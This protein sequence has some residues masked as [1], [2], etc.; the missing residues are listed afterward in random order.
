MQKKPAAADLAAPASMATQGAAMDRRITRSPWRRAGRWLPATAIV[1]TIG[2]LGIGF[3]LSPGA[4]SLVVSADTLSSA[5]VTSA[6]FQDYLPVRATVAPLHTV[7]VS[8]IEAG[9]VQS[10]A[11]PDGASVGQGDRLAVLVNPQLQRDVGTQEA[12]IAGQLGSV[13][14][15]RLALQQT[16][17]TEDNVIADTGY[18]L[19]KAQR[20]LAI[21]QQLHAQGFE[22]DAGVRSF[23]DEADYDRTRLRVLR[24]ARLRDQSVASRQSDAI[25][26]TA[27]RLQGN[28]DAVQASLS[29]L[30]LRAP[31][32]G[33]LTAFPLQS[34]QTLKQGDLV[35]QI[36]S[37]HA[38][39]LDA[40][41]DEFYL[42]RVSE[43][44]GATATIGGA[45][46]AMRVSR[47]HPQVSNGQFR[48]ELVFDAAP[49]AGLRRGESVQA[50]ITLGRTE[51]ALVLPNGAWLES[52]GGSA[53]FVLSADGRSA[54]KRAITVGRRNPEQVEITAGLAPGER[55]ITSSLANDLKFDRL[56]IR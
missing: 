1:A 10:V 21:R 5:I 27:S 49:P 30:V 12:T 4:G 35:G 47:V 23:S 18:Q 50:R 9:T 39:R 32:T 28:L 20:D 7:L 17:T 11:V 45:E 51:T 22:S 29:A 40:D 43:A 54:T 24:A 25:D 15:Q 6:P 37:E 36:D 3:A 2:A 13:S 44:Q 55:A 52:G 26:Q 8:A 56:L 46:M 19:L 41:I 34:G 33:R 42:G 38:Y 16:L 14:A 48:A 53:A 31:V